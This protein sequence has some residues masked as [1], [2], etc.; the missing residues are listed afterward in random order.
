MKNSIRRRM[1]LGGL[2]LAAGLTAFLPARAAA[3]DARIK[4]SC[5]A[6]CRLACCQASGFMCSCY[7]DTDGYSVCGCFWT[8]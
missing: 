4:G 6:D 1:L 3:A 2:A 5:G 8:Y 7:C